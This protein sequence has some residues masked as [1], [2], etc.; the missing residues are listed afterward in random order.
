M[1]NHMERLNHQQLSPAEFQ[2][3][4][5]HFPSQHH[6]VPSASIIELS[7]QRIGSRTVQ[8]KLSRADPEEKQAMFEEIIGPAHIL[9][10]SPY[11]N[12]VIQKFFEL[13]N[14]E[15]V[16]QLASVIQRNFMALTLDIHGCR[17]VQKAIAT[18]PI[19]RG[20][21][22]AMQLKDHVLDAAVDFHGNHVVQ[23]IL[24]TFQGSSELQF[25]IDE[26]FPHLINLSM[27]QCG[28]RVIQKI[29]Y[30][31]SDRQTAPVLSSLFDNVDELI[32]DE[33]GNYVVQHIIGESISEISQNLFVLFVVLISENSKQQDKSR[34][35]G[36]MCGKVFELSQQKFSSNVV[37][38]CIEYG[39]FEERRLLI[40]EVCSLQDT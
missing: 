1:M 15:H 31:C 30:C 6:R 36:A 24:E 3:S 14:A 12:F 38:K 34:F 8:A 37:E 5:H 22:L 17:V 32:S 18:I 19:L 7:F 28:C 21:D 29:L 9:M 11:G 20:L 35:I 4:R 27:D 16:S 23:K 33:H 2:F 25:I 13:G 10:T 40:E 26:V 39:T